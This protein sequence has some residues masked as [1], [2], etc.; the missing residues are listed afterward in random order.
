MCFL[1]WLPLILLF[2]AGQIYQIYN[3]Y[4]KIEKKI[5]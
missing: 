2:L 3:N 1:V 5:L 4:H